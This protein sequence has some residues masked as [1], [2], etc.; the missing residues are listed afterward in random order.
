MIK[1]KHVRYIKLGKGGCWEKTALAAN[2]LHLGHSHIPHAIAQSGEEDAIKAAAMKS[3]K[4]RG[5]ATDDT[6]EV[7]DFYNLGVDCLWITFSGQKMWWTFAEPQVKWIGPD[8]D[9]RGARVRKAVGEWSC[10][11]IAGRELEFSQLSSR[12]TKTSGYRRSICG[13]D[14]E[15]AEYAIRRIN[16]LVE[17]IVADAA[18]ATK[19]L[20][21]VTQRGIEALHWRDFETLADLIFARSGWN[22]MSPIGGNQKDIDLQLEQPSTGEIAT[23]QVKASASQATF[24]ECVARFEASGTSDR[25]FFVS[26]SPVRIVFPDNPQIRL[27]AG[28]EL[29]R[30]VTRLGLHDWVFEKIR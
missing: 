28:E 22:R 23:V 6:R 3:R 20:V 8:D 19:R 13:L 2:E 29:A 27:W 10:K 24:D 17:P 11:D 4:G 26:H 14:D 12:L 5:A 21:E 9:V 18:E 16:G 30:T 25:F 1:P 15:I 7:M